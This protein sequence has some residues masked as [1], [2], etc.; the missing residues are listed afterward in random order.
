MK[1]VNRQ[2]GQDLKDLT[3]WLNA[4]KICGNISKTEAALFK[5]GRKQAVSPIYSVLL[6]LLT[7]INHE[8]KILLIPFLFIDGAIYVN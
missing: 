3:Y 5:S 1:T 4:R 8:E 6:H 7:I 2:D